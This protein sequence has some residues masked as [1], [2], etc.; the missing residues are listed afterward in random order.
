MDAVRDRLLRA[1]R[2]LDDAGISYAVIGG[3][4]VASWVFAADPSAVRNTNDVDILI[5]RASLDDVRRAL[6][7]GGFRYRHAAGID[8]FLD[9][10]GARARD[11]VR[12]LFANEKVREEYVQPTPSVTESERTPQ[13]RVLTLEALVRMKLTSN[14]D[15]DRTHVRDM[16]G[17]GLIDSTWPERFHPVLAERLRDI[18]A[19]PE[20]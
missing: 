9:G 16:I 11:A 15:K 6:E 13:F 4:A 3:N 19:T 18:L 2:L 12:I 8:M 5:D 20:G 7:H 14:R 10:P 17:V 1:T